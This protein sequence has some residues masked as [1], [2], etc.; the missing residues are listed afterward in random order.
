MNHKKFIELLGY[1]AARGLREGTHRMEVNAAYDA[2]FDAGILARKGE[3]DEYPFEDECL[4]D[5]DMRCS[6]FMCDGC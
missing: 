1:L 2:G 6:D 3:E 5:P 4:R